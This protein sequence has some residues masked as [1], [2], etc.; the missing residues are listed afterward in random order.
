METLAEAPAVEGEE[1]EGSI[2]VQDC[3]SEWRSTGLLY[4]DWGRRTE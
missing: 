4:T 3:F 1:Y 2:L